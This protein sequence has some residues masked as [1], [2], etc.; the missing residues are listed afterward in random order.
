MTPPP[1][2]A[3]GGVTYVVPRFPKLSETFILHEVLELERAGTRVLLTALAHEHP[4]AVHP[5]AAERE[6]SARFASDELLAVLRAQGHWLRRRPG[7][8]LRLWAQAVAGNLRSPKF[9]VRALLAVP[10]GAWFGRLAA[11][12]GSQRVHAHY[13]THSALAALVAARLADLP[14]SFTAHAHDL[15]VDRSMLCEKVAAADLVVTISEYNR[16][17]I[18]QECPGV[19]TRVE[20]VRTG[21]DLSTFVAAPPP[22]DDTPLRLACVASLEPYKGQHHLVDAVARLQAAGV[23]V[24]CELAGEG[25]DREALE[26]QVR[27]AGLEEQVVLLGGQTKDEVRALLDRSHVFVLPSIVTETGKREGIPVAL[28][29]AMASGRPVVATDISGISELVED[30]VTGLLVREKDPAALAGA[31]E[32]LA[33]D[34]ELRDR[35]ARAGRKRVEEE[36]DLRRTTGQLRA[37]LAP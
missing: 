26:A 10:A 3:R 31:V 11:E 25:E 4:E 19:K 21:A 1:G 9:L 37:L 6:A 36:Y 23:A 33:A 20:V 8:Y 17:L 13:A 16:R 28:M 12:A 14:L 2:Q 24:R 22:P 34:P 32:R 5:A 30:G 29:E 27:A 35:L 7:R 15:Y 18:A